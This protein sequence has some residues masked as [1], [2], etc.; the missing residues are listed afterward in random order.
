MAKGPIVTDAVEALIA[1]V[2]QKHPKWKAPEVRYWVSHRLRK[3]NPKLPSGWPSLST[4]QKVLATVRR[5]AKDCNP[6]EKPW[7]MAT[8]DEYPI[9]PEAVPSV[10]KVWKFRIENN[11]SLTIGE[12]K[13]AARLSG[14]LEEIEKLSFKASIYARAESI[15]ALAERIFDS[16]E[17]DKQLMGLPKVPTKEWNYFISL[18]AELEARE[19]LLEIKVVQ[20]EK[21]ETKLAQNEQTLAQNEQ[22]IE[23]LSKDLEF[24]NEFSNLASEIMM[25]MGIV[26]DSNDMEEI[27]TFCKTMRDEWINR[28]PDETNLTWQD[29]KMKYDRYFG[30]MTPGKIVKDNDNSEFTEGGKQ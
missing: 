26:P 9:P 23:Q 6:Q 30:D 14:L 11:A 16:T 20:R 18:M 8:L 19:Q 15:F 12:A 21:L 10:L 28:H 5:K 29:F 4:V 24:I 3:D 25:R 7:S 17:L 1:A 13:W 2:Y 22:T 27:E